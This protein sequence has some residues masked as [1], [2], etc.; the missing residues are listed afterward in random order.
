MWGIDERAMKFILLILQSH[1]V[2]EILL[3]DDWASKLRNSC[4]F[5]GY[6]VPRLCKHMAMYYFTLHPLIHNHAH[7][8][9]SYKMATPEIWLTHATLISF[10]LPKENGQPFVQRVGW[11][12]FRRSGWEYMWAKACLHTQMNRFVRQI[13]LERDVF[14]SSLS[15]SSLSLYTRH[16]VK[17]MQHKQSIWRQRT[18][19]L[20]HWI[21]A[22]HEGDENFC[23]ISFAVFLSPHPSPCKRWNIKEEL[24][25]IQAINDSHKVWFEFS[26][27]FPIAC[28]LWVT[29]DSSNNCSPSPYLNRRTIRG[30]TDSKPWEKKAGCSWKASA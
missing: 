18:A 7:P 12:I 30:V 6:R 16:P 21:M 22:R 23:F 3:R 29:Q 5:Q 26:R 2:I 1:L 10:V 4:L 25:L 13:W 19:P 28:F 11:L 27:F 17:L 14:F 24:L 9:Y 8:D 15:L 20:A